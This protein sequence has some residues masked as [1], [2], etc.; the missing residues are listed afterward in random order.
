IAVTTDSA[1][2]MRT[3]IEVGMPQEVAWLP[4]LAHLIPLVL[5][6]ELFGNEEG[7][8]YLALK[9]VRNLA[10]TLARYS[11]L[12]EYYRQIYSREHNGH[13]PNQ[14]LRQAR[15]INVAAASRVT[16]AD[17][18]YQSQGQID[19]LTDIELI[20]GM[21]EAKSTW[22]Q[23]SNYPKSD[24]AQATVLLLRTGLDSIRGELKSEL[25][26]AFRCRL[27]PK[28]E[29]YLKPLLAK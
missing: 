18:W 14:Y 27:V 16:G 6:E 7:A 23:G 5:K 4:C 19:F 15:I 17:D 20:L 12:W 22:L 11:K 13:F 10:K 9:P 25:G 21:F 24:L 8:V 2:N 29:K 1:A 26:E 28:W 3:A